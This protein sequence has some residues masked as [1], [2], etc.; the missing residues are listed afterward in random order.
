MHSGEKVELK[1]LDLTTGDFIDD[2]EDSMI[3]WLVHQQQESE[4]NESRSSPQT[5]S[6]VANEVRMNAEQ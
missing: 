4:L 2:D 6:F 3:E 1:Y 5:A